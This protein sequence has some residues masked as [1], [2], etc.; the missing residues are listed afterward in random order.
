MATVLTIGGAR[1]IGRFTVREFLHRGDEVTL[2]SRGKTDDP[3]GDRVDRVR[4]DRKDEDDLREAAAAVG[5]DVVV[6]FA[7]YQPADVRTATTVFDDVDAYVYVSST[8]AYE[9]SSIPLREDDTPLMSCAPEQ[10]RDDSHETYGRRK[11]E[12]DRALFEAADRG[13]DAMSVRPT[14]IYGPHDYTERQDYWI[15]RVN[16]F[17]RIAVP[18]DE[19]WMP[20][21]LGYVEDV[22]RAIRIVA[23]R[24]EPGEAYNVASRDQC[25]LVDLIEHVANAL[26]TS[27]TVAHASRRDLAAVGLSPED[28]SLCR[29]YP[30]FVST[31]KLAD[32][33][34]TSTPYEEGWAG[35][36]EASLETDSDG[37]Q[38]GPDRDTEERLLE[39]ISG[40]VHRIDGR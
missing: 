35:A 19:Y 23:E 2:F 15:D 24:G 1:F 14:A 21:H 13:V 31:A 33:G 29:S 27:V 3:F 37:T 17:D 7:A 28:F 6:D 16:R 22:A 30:S 40:S 36:V 32:L 38:H 26:N 4:G 8:S 10:A 9:W 12:G 25:R 39:T 20:I 18:G 5:P 34:W 11:A